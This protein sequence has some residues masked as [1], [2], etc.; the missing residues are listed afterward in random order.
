[1][2]SVLVLKNASKMRSIL[3]GSIPVPES[4]TE[5]AT[6]SAA[7]TSDLTRSKREIYFLAA[8]EYTRK[9]DKPGKSD[10]V[11]SLRQKTTK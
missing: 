10:F 1:M 2:P 5:I 3:A 11:Q 7:T 8:Q 4:A 6:L 9:V